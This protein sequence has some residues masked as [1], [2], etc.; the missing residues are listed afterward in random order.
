MN[1]QNFLLRRV[2]AEF[3]GTYALVTTGCGAIIVSSETGIL[4]HLGI[5][6]TFGLVIVVM[7]AATAHLSGAHFNLPLH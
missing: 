6:S 5:A 3:L 7:V 1:R 4:S 2:G